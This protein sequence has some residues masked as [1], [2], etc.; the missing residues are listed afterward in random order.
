MENLL[1]Y[2]IKANGL[3][4]LFYLMYILFLR[5]ET[6]FVSNRWY[7]IFGLFLSLVLPLI[8]FT[9]TIWLEPVPI[10]DLYQETL[11]INSSKTEKN[12]PEITIDWSLII[13]STYLTISFLI[14]CKIGVELVSFYN[15]IRNQSKQKAIDFTLIHSTTT[16][17]PFSFFHFI[18]I[19]TNLFSET[20]LHHI[21]THESI[22]VKQKHSIDVLFGKLFC[23][24]FW[25]NPIIWLYR[26]AMLQNLEFIADSKTFEQIENKYEY[27]KTLLKVVTHQHDLSITN[28]F[29][30]SLIK[31][32]IVMLHTNQS[33]KRNAWKYAII[34]PLLVGFMLLFQIE[35]VAQVKEVTWTSINSNNSLERIEFIITKN[36][37]NA[38]IIKETELLKKEYNIELKI[39]K[40]KRN[41]ENE[42]IALDAKFEDKDKTSGK[43]S[44]KGD[45]PID[46]VRFFKELNENGKGN[47]GF[48]RNNIS[49]VFA[50]MDADKIEWNEAKTIEIKK[51]ATDE[52]I[53]IINGKEYKKEEMKGKI[54]ELDGAIEVNEDE[55]S[56]KKIVIFKGKTTLS[57][58]SKTVIFFDEI[59]KK[60]VSEKPNSEAAYALVAA[61]FSEDETFNKIDRI[62][63]D[64]T[65][66]P[67]KALILFNG[68]EINY[69][70]IDKI[71]PKTISSFGNTI[72]SHAIKKYG[73]KGKNGVIF[74]NTKSYDLD[75]NPFM[76]E[77]ENNK[78]IEL[79]VQENSNFSNE[80]LE[81]RRIKREQ[82]LKE[83]KKMI[84][85]RKIKIEERKEERENKIEQK[86]E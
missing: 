2:F 31:K 79:K 65:V 82:L 11:P 55:K 45:R 52:M 41:K 72:A 77:Y 58:E 28:Q 21:L 37:T 23:A 80:E 34:L 9:K 17:N 36:T 85:E 74:I 57:D 60:K 24:L 6:F 70:D 10:A 22:H 13:L 4:I 3:I 42:I 69:E 15:K 56:G 43:I 39:S 32:R 86:K 75:N 33:H 29:Y 18:V 7:F 14:I 51:S 83:R 5:K 78:Q 12:I 59:N 73:E 54:A 38:E 25:V 30:Q 40:I 53:Y 67:K 49:T 71:D 46:P 44:I 8:T 66:D 27:Q 68:K 16:E 76:K 1:L 48:D 47:I 26:K 62:K 35:T 63:S 64:K 50:K 61:E 19:N 81:E 20:E 84:E